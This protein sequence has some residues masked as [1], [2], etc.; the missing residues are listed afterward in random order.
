MKTRYLI[1]L[2]ACVLTWTACDNRYLDLDPVEE[3]VVEGWIENGHAPIVFVSK[4][5]PASS[6]PRK[7]DMASVIMR[8]ANVY[9]DCNGK[10]SYL[11]ARLSDKYMLQNYFTTNEISGQVG[12]SYPLHVEYQDFKAT[13]TCTIP[14]PCPIDTA[15]MLHKAGCDTLSYARMEFTNNPETKTYYQ[16]FLRVGA[17]DTSAF[18]A[19]QYGKLASD[20]ITAGPVAIDVYNTE[21]KDLHFHS[22]DKLGLKLATMEKCMADFWQKFSDS[23]GLSSN[24][25]T[26]MHTNC[27]GNVEGALGYW[28]GYGISVRELQVK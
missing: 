8:Y 13:A 22:G 26:P 2:L 12:Q 9:I 21:S 19:V 6:T 7:L 10:R 25:L 20:D 3:L 27:K 15:Y 16:Y 1:L 5:L 23:A 14:E 18:R 24:M 17:A 28:A 4:S 11:T